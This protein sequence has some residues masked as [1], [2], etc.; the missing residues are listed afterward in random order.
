MIVVEVL[1]T[2]HCPHEDDAISLVTM[3]AQETGVTPR[4]TLIE[5]GDL[6]QAEQ[7]HFLGS[8]TIRINGS[9]IAPAKG[10]A[11]S[12]SCRLYHTTHGLSG[13]PEL[14]LVRA[15]LENARANE[16]R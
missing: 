5:I 6:E 11:A 2:E 3:A 12:L 14:D 13:V 1:V 9:D 15:A 10:Q 4:L 16:L 8:P 7:Q